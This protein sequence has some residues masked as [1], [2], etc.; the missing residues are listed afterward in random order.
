MKI[1]IIWGSDSGDTEDTTMT[2]EGKLTSYDLEVINV[3]EASVED[4]RKFVA[5]TRLHLSIVL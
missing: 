4:F 5:S 3:A 1:G 2:M